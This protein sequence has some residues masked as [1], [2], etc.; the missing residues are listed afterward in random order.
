[1]TQPASAATSAPIAAQEP[2]IRYLA[3]GRTVGAPTLGRYLHTLIGGAAL[4]V[5]PP[6]LARLLAQHGQRQALHAVERWW[7]RRIFA[8]PYERYVVTPLHE[9]FADVPALL[10]LPLPL[11]FA[12]RDELFAWRVLGPYL[13]DTGQLCITPERGRWSYRRLLTL[14]GQVF[15]AG[16]SVVIFPQGTILGIETNFLRGAFALA[17]A[18]QRPILPIAL[19]GGHR[20]WEHPFTP[21]LRYGQRISLRVLPPI[22][23]ADIRASSPDE[24]RCEVQRRVKAEALAGTM[25]APRHY[26]PARDGYWDGFAFEVDPAFPALAADIARHRQQAAAGDAS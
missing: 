8:D 24:L 21:R 3:A 14:A 25:A 9:S 6:A 20:V 1:M 7:A 17:N 13:R 5:A 4:F 18:L 2:P 23:V 19:T 11:R 15:A 12:A 22:A 16:E 10:H 26:M